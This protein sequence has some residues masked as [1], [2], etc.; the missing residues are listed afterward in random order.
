MAENDPA[1]PLPGQQQTADEVPPEALATPPSCHPYL[2]E[3]R[4]TPEVRAQREAEGLP[5]PPPRKVNTPGGPGAAG[6]KHRADQERQKAEAERRAE[7]AR[8]QTRK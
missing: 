5:P 4:E 3:E 7:H 2:P 8:A 1:K 6:E